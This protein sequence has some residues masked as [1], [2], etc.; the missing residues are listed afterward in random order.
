MPTRKTM[1]YNYGMFF[2]T[3]TCYK[4]IPLIDKVNGYDIVYKWFVYLKSKGHYINGYVIMP[5]HVHVLISFTDTGQSINTIIGNGKRFMAYE[6]IQRLME[7]K[8]NELLSILGEDIEKERKENNKLH[9]V[10]ELSFDWK[11]CVG[12]D[13]I[14]QKL[15]YMHANPC[16]GKWN[17]CN[18]PVEYV[19]SSARY[20]LASEE[21]LCEITNFMMMD[22]IKLS[23]E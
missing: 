10:W 18:S 13:F 6:I 19:H 20:Y 12:K 21:G 17:L 4:W 5:N 2:I 23:R 11:E 7:N 14:R 16:A 15:D 8:E 3:F 1:P 9:N 22:D